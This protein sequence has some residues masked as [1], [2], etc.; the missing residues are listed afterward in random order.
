MRISVTD[1][2]NMRCSYCVSGDLLKL[3]PAGHLLSL[4]EIETVVR[5]SMRLGFDS[6]RFTG[7]E[8]LVR[9]GVL[10]LIGRVAALE[11]VQRLSLST[12]GSLL[13]KHLPA[14]AAAGVRSLNIS[15]DTLDP[16]RFRA[17]TRGGELAPVLD[18]IEAAAADGRFRVK[19]NVVML[20]GFNDDEIA[21]LAALTLTRALSVRFIEYMPFGAWQRGEGIA[22]VNP[23]I[24]VDEARTRLRSNFP[25]DQDVG[26]PGGD[27]PATYVKICGARGFVGF[28]SPVL[29]PFCERCNRLRLTADGEIKSCLLTDDRSRLRDWMRSPV[30]SFSELVSRIRE[31]VVA[32]P[33]KH[34]Y[35]RNFDMSTVG[36]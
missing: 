35:S 2:C 5:A 15:L 11:G 32:K 16:G 29:A 27:G 14:L 28:I 24:S 1:R 8:P 3:K 20:R 30:F 18:G 36:G 22:D 23:V 13:H 9:E 12:N 4:D 33:E 31:A 19:L 7:G 17:I 6:F 10:E 21:D 26:G 34:N 25:L